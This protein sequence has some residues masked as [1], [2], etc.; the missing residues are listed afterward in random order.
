MLLHRFPANLPSKAKYLEFVITSYLNEVYILSNR[1]E[2]YTKKITRLYKNSLH[3]KNRIDLLLEFSKRL[4]NSFRGI[5]NMRGLHVHE[6]R[7]R[8]DDLDSLIF[9]EIFFKDKSS[10]SK[11]I[12]P[13]YKKSLAQGKKKWLQFL[14]NRNNEIQEI[15][16]AYF[17]AMHI[18]VFDD[19][20]NFIV[21]K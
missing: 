16:D 11:I 4:N 7:Y 14:Q 8:D 10:L 19:K 1:L 5:N 2:A 21:P 9:L 17:T 13:I 15:L 3:I 6:R 20:G 18:V 12:N